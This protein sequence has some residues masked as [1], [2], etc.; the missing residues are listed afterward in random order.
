MTL[1]CG[2]ITLEEQEPTYLFLHFDETV[3]A[4][5]RLLQSY[6]TQGKRVDRYPTSAKFGKQLEY[7]NKKGIRYAVIL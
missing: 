2:L 6:V 3:D 7:A 5:N 1:A 4:T